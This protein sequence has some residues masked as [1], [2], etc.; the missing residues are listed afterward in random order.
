MTPAQGEAVMGRRPE[1][2][3]PHG[4][5]HDS[6]NYYFQE[7]IVEGNRVGVKFAEGRV[8]DWW[9]WPPDHDYD[10]YDGFF[11]RLFLWW[12]PDLD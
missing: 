8:D 5:Y 10:D 1:K 6:A 2:T 7:W 3:Y 11:Y 12:M 9:S 4:L